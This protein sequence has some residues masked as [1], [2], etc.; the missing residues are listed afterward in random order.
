MEQNWIEAAIETTT[1]GIEPV[2]AL[3]LEL[4]LGGYAVQDAA[5]F[6]EFL[7]GK[8][9]QWDYIDEDLMRLREAPTVLTAYLADNAQGAER[10]QALQAGLAR[11]RALD[12]AGEWG[13]LSVTLSGIREEDWAN[14]WKQWYK[15]LKIGRRLVV[16]PSW[17][18]YAPAPEEVI[19][20]LDPGMAFGT[21]THETTQLCLQML[22]EY[23]P[24][25]KTILDVGCGSGIL[26]ASAMLLGARE[27][28]GID[29]D[30]NAVRVARENAE[31]NGVAAEY[32]RG[33][34]ATG[35][36]GRYDIIFANIVADAI[37]A[38]APDVPRRL[39][40]GGVLIASG[41]IDTRADEVLA[42]IEAAGLRILRREELRG[43]VCVACSQ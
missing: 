4:E 28:L 11:L 23:A 30:E 21:G 20:R 41:I 37:K 38:L 19:L 2:G 10:M 34:L 27:A 3:L 26:S 31:A 8:T 7:A 5:D 17:E 16:C 39:A 18:E 13:T 32:R 14:A 22:D 1:Q 29:I 25:G 42:A 12:T 33:D 6:E 43:W 35:V 36:D 9:G 24:A 40:E 15:P